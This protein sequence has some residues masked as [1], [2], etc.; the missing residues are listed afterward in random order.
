VPAVYFPLGL[1]NK[2]VMNYR[3]IKASAF[4]FQTP[5][6]RAAVL[7][8]LQRFENK[9]GAG[10]EVLALRRSYGVR[11]RGSQAD[12]AEELYRLIRQGKD[13]LT[14]A[15]NLNKLAARVL[16]VTCPRLQEIM[17][18]KAEE[19]AKLLETID[20]RNLPAEALVTAYIVTPADLVHIKED[21]V[22]VVQTSQAPA[23]AQEEGK[24]APCPAAE[25]G[26]G[27]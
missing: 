19:R 22:L 20:V 7:K 8:Q 17:R 26:G 25:A 27:I 23:P 14:K 12:V 1:E 24:C 6:Q 3:V 18:R 2:R 16:A 21:A 4:I 5:E 13:N 15:F 10:L 11:R 9:T